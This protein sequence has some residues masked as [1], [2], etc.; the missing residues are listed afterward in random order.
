MDARGSLFRYWGKAGENE[1]GYPSWHPLVYHSLDVAAVGCLFL[2][3]DKLLCQ[4]LSNPSGLPPDNLIPL[5]TFLLATH[6][7]G[8]FAEGFQNLRKDLYE[9]LQGGKSQK[10]YTA[11]H[12]VLGHRFWEEEIIPNSVKEGWWGGESDDLEGYQDLLS[13]FVRAITGHH[14]FPPAQLAFQEPLNRQFSGSTIQNILSFV[15][16]IRRELSL[17]PFPQEFLKN[18]HAAWLLAGL[19][20]L[21]DWIGSNR[22]WFPYH[23]IE[24]PLEDY[25]KEHALPKASKAIAESG[26][27]SSSRNPITDINSAFPAIITPTPLQ[28]FT[29]IVPISTGPQLF[30]VEEVTGA[31]KTEAALI[32]AYRLISSG[33]GEGIFIALPT[34][35][36]ANAMF[37]RI[38]KIPDQ[39]FNNGAASL[40]LA[41]SFRHLYNFGFEEQRRDYTHSSEEDSASKSCSTWL[42][43]NREKALLA[44]IG[45]G[46]ID[47]ALMAILP[48]RHQSLRLLGLSRNILIVDEV[49]ACDSYMHRLLCRLLQFHAALGGSAILLSATLPSKMREELA[50]AF[51]SGLGGSQRPVSDNKYP[52][53]TH[54]DK[55]GGKTSAFSSRPEMARKIKIQFIHD[56]EG[57]KNLLEKEVLKGGKCGCWIRNTVADALEAHKWL[58]PTFG[59]KLTLFHARFAMGDR[60]AIEEEVLRRYGKNSGPSERRGNLLIATQVVEQSLDLDFD[61]MIS[62]LAP[63][64]LLIQ[65]A[66]RLCRHSRDLAGNT[67]SAHDQR[68]TPILNLF[69]PLLVKD[70]RRNW[71]QSFFP[72]AARVYPHHGQLWLAATMLAEKMQIQIPEDLRFLIEGVYGEGAAGSIPPEL[73]ATEINAEGKDKGEAALGNMNALNLEDAYQVTFN[74][75]QEDIYIPT[76]LGKPMVTIFLGKWNGNKIMP[77]FDHPTHP[78]DLSQVNIREAMISKCNISDEIAEEINSK[79]PNK[80]K[81]GILLPLRETGEK[82]VGDAF[83]GKGKP[84]KVNYDPMT[85]LW[86]EKG[87]EENGV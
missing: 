30:I 16:K 38:E 72:K 77:W 49:H 61:L 6:D 51:R 52:L 56:R 19:T 27:L 4:K 70:P 43:D 9:L 33:L 18:A 29:G 41:H 76:R 45:V 85:G 64:D 35:A 26:V 24:M 58:I 11:S 15:D 86:P 31:G 25:W 82:W 1:W 80:G 84:V 87:D 54:V 59:D 55:G 81:W 42:S 14:G 2:K 7:V 71:Y 73:L 47:Q 5:F 44:Q 32:L 50:N 68:G 79:L 28:V 66:G 10:A 75:W 46:T 21:A 65:R 17:K 53:V 69:A 48:A 3:K 23:P 60:L 12:C 78:W 74:H 13:P 62:D 57:L 63:I 22:D 8:K 40:V 34:M 37:K 36:T 39:F 83:D 20:V 67:I